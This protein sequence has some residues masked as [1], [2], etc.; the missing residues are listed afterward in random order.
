[1]PCVS[2]VVGKVFRSEVV[3]SWRGHSVLLFALCYG[4][5][6]HFALPF[7]FWN[8]TTACFGGFLLPKE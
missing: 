8:K 5:K 4:H 1:M 7:N 2:G 6:I 3:A